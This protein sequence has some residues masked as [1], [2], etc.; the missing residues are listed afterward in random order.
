RTV[1]QRK[2]PLQPRA[3]ATVDAVLEAAAR[4]LETRGTAGFNTNA[5][6]ALAGVS[7]G[8]LYQYFPSK[9]V[10]MAALARREAAVFA[11]AL[12]AALDAA[13][14]APLDGALHVLAQTAVA[15]QTVRPRLAR[16]LDF[17]EQRLDLGAE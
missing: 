8:S 7:V 17:E 2:T 5:V 6:A 16:I 15:H 13:S 3:R 4:I 9:E 10:I 11:R 1:T 12:D 14:G